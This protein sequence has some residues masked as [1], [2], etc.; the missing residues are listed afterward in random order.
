MLTTLL[1]FIFLLFFNDLEPAVKEASKQIENFTYHK[2]KKRCA[3]LTH[4]VS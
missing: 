4:K 3:S 2:P 1:Q